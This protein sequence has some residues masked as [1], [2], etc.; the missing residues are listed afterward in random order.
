MFLVYAGRLVHIQIIQGPELAAK[1]QS[2][3]LQNVILPAIRGNIN[4]INGVPIATTVIA[5]NVTCDQTLISDPA[6]AAALLSPVLGIPIPE[7]TTSLT[8]EKRFNYIA[9]R[10]TPEKWKEVAALDIAGIFS[11]PTTTRVYPNGGLAGSVVG[12]V[13][14]EGHGLGGL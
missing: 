10:I 13:G 6:G 3:R 7:L 4:D 8:G 1:S 12:Y 14:A 9:K 5:K 2:N 11:E